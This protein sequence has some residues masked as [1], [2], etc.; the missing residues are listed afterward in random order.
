M[1]KV[2]FNYLLLAALTVSAAFTSCAKDVI[3]VELPVSAFDGKIT[4]IVENGDD[5]NSVIERV[6]ITNHYFEENINDWVLYVCGSGSYSGG[7]FEI[8]LT[9]TLN[10]KALKNI[11][12]LFNSVENLNISDKT[13]VFV[14]VGPSMICAF[15]SNN[16]I[17][18]FSYYKEDDENHTQAFFIYVDKDVNIVGSAIDDISRGKYPVKMPLKKGWNVLYHTSTLKVPRA[19]VE[20]TTKEVSGLKWYFNQR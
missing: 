13:A 10:Y 15:A 2:F 8:I 6:E 12:S 18:N 1:K 17:G 20:Y 4:A 7:G 16:F 14:S 5:F 11:E 3:V 19:V 9:Q